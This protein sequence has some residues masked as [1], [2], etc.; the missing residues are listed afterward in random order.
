MFGH[1][2]WRDLAVSSCKETFCGEEII[3]CFFFFKS[4]E[5]YSPQT[6][7]EEI[8]LKERKFMRV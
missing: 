4:R 5:S 8:I 7:V 1:R 2:I 6:E 3:V